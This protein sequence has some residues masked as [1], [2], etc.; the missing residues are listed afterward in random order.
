V[1]ANGTAWP[2]TPTPSAVGLVKLPAAFAA[3]LVRAQKIVKEAPKSSGY[4]KPGGEWVPTSSTDDVVQVCKPALADTEMAL[5]G[6][7]SD[8]ERQGLTL[9]RSWLLVHGPTGDGLQFVTRFEIG[10][11]KDKSAALSFA[12]AL[13]MSMGD[14]YRSVLGIKRGDETA[15]VLPSGGN[16]A[17]P[18]PPPKAPPKSAPDPQA[19]PWPVRVLTRG[20]EWEQRTAKD[21]AHAAQLAC[22]GLTKR[23]GPRG[24]KRPETVEV[25]TGGAVETYSVESTAPGAW[26]ATLVPASTLG[27]AKAVTEGSDVER[28]LGVETGAL[29][30]GDESETTGKESGGVYQTRSE[31]TSTGAVPADASTDESGPETGEAG[32]GHALPLKPALVLPSPTVGEGSSK[33]IDTVEGP[34]PADQASRPAE[35]APA[36]SSAAVPTAPAAASVHSGGAPAGPTQRAEGPQEAPLPPSVSGAPSLAPLG[37]CADCGLPL[38][39]EP[40]EDVPCCPDSEC[41]SNGPRPGPTLPAPDWME[42]EYDRVAAELAASVP[43]NQGEAPAPTGAEERPSWA[44]TPGSSEP[45]GPPGGSAPSS[46][47]TADGTTPPS[48]TSPEGPATTPPT[49]ATSAPP[50]AAG[51][52]ASHDPATPGGETQSAPGVAVTVEPSGSGVRLQFGRGDQVERCDACK[53]PMARVRVWL[54]DAWQCLNAKCPEGAE[55][56][57]ALA[58]ALEKLL[59]P[60]SGLRVNAGMEPPG[61]VLDAIDKLSPRPAATGGESQAAGGAPTGVAIRASFG[62]V[63]MGPDVLGYR[64][65]HNGPTVPLPKPPEAG[66]TARDARIAADAEDL[67]RAALGPLAPPKPKRHRWSLT[68]PPGETRSGMYCDRCGARK[69]KA[70]PPCTGPATAPA[71]GAST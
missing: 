37:R 23:E 11:E 55:P 62:G 53:K 64:I 50:S 71:G 42:A 46:T 28:V 15:T 12:G 5:V 30:G 24:G 26:C 56:T 41:V 27:G 59:A 48:A 3:A 44:S 7:G 4:V 32:S 65:A 22:V 21:A 33:A 1:S 9:A 51:P 60:A 54:V 69:G 66:E 29:F 57:P 38:E 6:L 13:T 58:G 47:P 19:R 14:A 35:G 31:P 8:V 2:G 40:T 52:V 68:R 67:T 34:A 43:T 10:A 39:H 45:A 63:V 16:P 18:P 25:D 70:A 20:A 61:R 36:P 17:A 49:T